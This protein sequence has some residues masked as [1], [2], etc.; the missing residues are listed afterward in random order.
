[1]NRVQLMTKILHLDQENEALINLTNS[2][3]EGNLASEL[4]VRLF[5]SIA[6]K[7]INNMDKNKGID[8]PDAMRILMNACYQQANEL[9]NI[10]EE[11]KNHD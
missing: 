10:L 7:V 5:N 1:M 3:K 9:N 2:C 8:R 11:H 4:L 6:I